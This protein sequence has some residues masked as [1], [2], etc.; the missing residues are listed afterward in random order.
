MTLLTDPSAWLSLA[1]LTVLEIVLGVD[2]VIFLSILVGRLPPERQRAA[3]VAGLGLAMLT[4]IA[5]LL[6]VTW[7][8]TLTEPMLRGFGREFSGRDLVLGAGGVFLLWKSVVE[9]HAAVEGPPGGT[10]R[11][12]ALASFTA[13]IV[14][15]AIIDI[16]FSLDSVFTAVGLV[17]QVPVMIA[18][19]VLAIVFMMFVA[20]G[21]SR[22]IAAHPT[23]KVLAL[24]FLILIGMALIAEAFEFHIPKAYLYVSMAFALG[25]E[26]LNTRARRTPAT[27]RNPAGTD[28]G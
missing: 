4:R 7:L 6:S 15:I 19:I 26:L 21:V 5:L 22:F 18:A 17:Q 13:V 2:N 24:A 12:P 25:V 10:R 3:R 16:V 1:T 11:A 14:Q 28:R 23:V 27:D 20:G 9:I 8:A